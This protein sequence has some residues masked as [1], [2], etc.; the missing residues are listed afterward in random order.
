MLRVGY[1]LPKRSVSIMKGNTSKV[2]RNDMIRSAVGNQA[3][4]SIFNMVKKYKEF[5]S[6][7]SLDSIIGT[8]DPHKMALY[9]RNL[10]QIS[11]NEAINQIHKGWESGKL[12]V[13]EEI[14]KEY[15]KAAAATNKLDKMNVTGLL[16][17][18][19]KSKGVN[20]EGGM[21]QAA[22]FSMMNNQ[23]GNSAGSS[24][25]EPLYL[26]PQGLT[27]KEHA[28]RFAG[29]V[30]ATFMVLAFIGALLG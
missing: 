12:P 26:A 19:N 3:H 1:A 27:Y 29:K 22:L 30:A 10:G 20:E 5:E 17:L 7:H 25:A 11:P 8:S 6:S 15:L 21:S 28:W 16:M 4:M 9:F 23:K 13:N 18:L 14:L 24:R 2:F